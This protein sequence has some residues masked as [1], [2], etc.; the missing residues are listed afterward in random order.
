M[1]TSQKKKN[2]LVSKVDKDIIFSSNFK[3]RK[4]LQI[5]GETVIKVSSQVL[6]EA[7]ICSGHVSYFN[8]FVKVHECERLSKIGH[9]D[10]CIYYNGNELYRELTKFEL[11]KKVRFK[12]FYE[13]SKDKNSFTTFEIIDKGVNNEVGFR[14]TIETDGYRSV[15]RPIWHTI[16]VLF[17]IPSYKKYLNA[18]VKGM[19]YHCETGLKVKKNQFGTHSRFSN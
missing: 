7:L 9:K 3:S 1:N 10:S 18:V 4:W 8:S 2:P 15:P 12:I 16:A 17:F 6:W 14:L 19:K 11:E 13:K 5:R